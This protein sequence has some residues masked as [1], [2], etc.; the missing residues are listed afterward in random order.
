[1]A[2]RGIASNKLDASLAEQAARLPSPTM[3]V[4]NEGFVTQLGRM[5]EKVE[6]KRATKAT[7]NCA[8]SAWP[9]AVINGRAEGPLTL[10]RSM[11]AQRDGVPNPNHG[12]F[13][14]ARHVPALTLS[15]E[16]VLDEGG[17]PRERLAD[18]QWFDCTP[19][20]T[21]GFFEYDHGSNKSL[22][23]L[24]LQ[25]YGAGVVDLWPT[26]KQLAGIHAKITERLRVYSEEGDAPIEALSN[27]QMRDLTEFDEADA[28]M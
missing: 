15:G 17:R 2:Y 20:V 23:R 6:R 14:V 1:M 19:Y 5:L 10:Y 21:L 18:F 26:E 27:E 7:G 12:R 9:R 22:M 8:N 24:M 16:P 28:P 11:R 4:A 13:Y 3:L 25:T